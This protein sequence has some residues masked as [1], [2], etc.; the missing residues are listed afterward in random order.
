MYNPRKVRELLEARGVKVKELG[1]YLGR[2]GN[3]FM[4]NLEQN[5]KV[6]T[7]E[8]VADFFQVPTDTFF[9]RS[10]SSSE[11]KELARLRELI[12]EKD[13]RIAALEQANRLLTEKVKQLDSASAAK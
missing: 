2:S 4:R 7:L 10:Y 11:D 3:S 1:E 9:E 12:E 5:I 13:G 8:K 6:S